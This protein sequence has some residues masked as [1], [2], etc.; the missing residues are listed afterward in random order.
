MRKGASKALR[1][2]SKLLEWSGGV[3]LGGGVE[4]SVGLERFEAWKCRGREIQYGSSQANFL[5]PKPEL[6][7]WFYK[8]KR[9]R[10]GGKNGG[11][12][13][14]SSFP[15]KSWPPGYKIWGERRCI[16]EMYLQQGARPAGYPGCR[17]PVG[18]FPW[19]VD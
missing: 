11:G 13:L 17:W 9:W 19:P 8:Q 5:T 3:V 2:P 18:Y 14:N 15:P 6:G 12:E 1:R 4:M 16:F 10:K 7:G